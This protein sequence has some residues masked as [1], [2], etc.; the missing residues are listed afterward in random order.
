MDLKK[1]IVVT[2]LILSIVPLIAEE[3]K[4]ETKA[5]IFFSKT[6]DCTKELSA[7]ID[8][9]KKSIYFAT[10]SLTDSYIAAALIRAKKRGVEV[11]GVT[12]RQN[13]GGKGAKF[14]ELLEGGIEIYLDGNSGLMHHKMIII[15]KYLVGTGSFNWTKNANEK[16]DENLIFLRGEE[17]ADVYYKEFKKVFWDA[18]KDSR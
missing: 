13:A 8:K 5:E 1:I 18:K 10:Y 2:C 11:A 12:E 16:N 4:I 3:V 17:L 9:A 15:D 7:R 6:D 14:K